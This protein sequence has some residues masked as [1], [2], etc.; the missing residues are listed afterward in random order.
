MHIFV[1]LNFEKVEIRQEYKEHC[2]AY[3]AAYNSVTNSANTAFS[4]GGPTKCNR[5]LQ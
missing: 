2:S 3:F 1:L 4:T 5:G